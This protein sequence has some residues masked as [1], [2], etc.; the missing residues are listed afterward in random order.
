ELFSHFIIDTLKAKFSVKYPRLADPH[1]KSYW[2]LYGL[3]QL[4]H[5][6]VVIAIWYMAVTH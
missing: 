1:Q 3:D 4:L 2:I 5:Q 6:L